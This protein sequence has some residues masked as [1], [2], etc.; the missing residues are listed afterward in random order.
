MGNHLSGHLGSILG[1]GFNLEL[2]DFELE[3]GIT[4]E[5]TEVAPVVCQFVSS[6]VF[7]ASGRYKVVDFCVPM[8]VYHVD[9]LGGCRPYLSCVVRR[10]RLVWLG[11]VGS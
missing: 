1:N 7:Q 9:H 2:R 5:F 4:Y 10:G 6:D 11:Y 3:V 8:G